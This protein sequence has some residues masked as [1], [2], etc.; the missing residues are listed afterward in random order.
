VP[1]L[2]FSPDGRL[3]ASTGKDR[4]LRLWDLASPETARVL[5]PLPAPGQALAY[6]VDGRLIA[7]SDYAS[8]RISL[9]SPAT[10]R[11]LGEVGAEPPH[12]GAVWSCAISPDGRY[13]A[14]VGG[15]LR[16]WTMD[17]DLLIS[18]NNTESVRLIYSEPDAAPNAA[19]ANVVFHPRDPQ[20]AYLSIMTSLSG[21]VTGLF[22]R[23]LTPEATPQLVTTN[24]N[25]SIIQVQ[26]FLPRTGSL[27]YLDRNR[28]VVVVHPGTREVLRRFQTLQPGESTSTYIG[29]I[30]VSPDESK[31]ALASPTGLGVD[32]WELA[33]GR[34]LYALPDRPGTVW[35]LAWSPDSR[36]LAISRANGE[37]ALWDTAEVEAQLA[38]LGLDP[39]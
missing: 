22:L 32:V 39:H 9:W 26:S 7:C 30:A 3:V 16:L 1:A 28:H 6:S 25:G 27:I 11:Q 10:G 4:T 35:W 34:R 24:S 19:T 15:G 29:N 5:G 18:A 13:L 8:G 17:P 21:F 37:I 23:D 38:R 36:R 12:P 2:E 20:L 33:T 14:A 31:L